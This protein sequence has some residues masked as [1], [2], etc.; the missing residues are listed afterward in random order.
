M[1]VA[2]TE[3]ALLAVVDA[4]RRKQVDAILGKA[5]ERAR[6]ILKEAHE[7]A[8]RAVRTALLEARVRAEER[9][10]TLQAGVTTARRLN[11]QQRAARI[12]AA[13]W[14][15]L[16]ETMAHRWHNPASRLRW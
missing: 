7:R 8:R 2:D 12:L 9:V 14:S 10:L 6:A 11:D 5:D 16:P 13:E 1:N 3:R 4:S 15:S